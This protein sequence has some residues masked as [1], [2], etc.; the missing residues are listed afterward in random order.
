MPPMA[1]RRPPP[2]RSFSFLTVAS[3]LFASGLLA[4]CEGCRTPGAPG[5]GA[6][7]SAEPP[8]LRLYL[9]SS[10]AGALE[11]CGCSPDQLGGFDRLAAYMRGQGAHAPNALFLEAGPLFFVHPTPHGEQATQDSWKAEAI[12]GALGRMHFAGWAP[13]LNDWCDGPAGFARLRERSK[14]DA[15]AANLR[16]EGA[17]VVP[18]ALREAGGVKVGLLGLSAPQRGGLGPAGVEVGPAPEALRGAIEGLKAQG[19]QIFVALAALPRG[20]A[21]RLA[22]LTPGLHVVLVGKTSEAEDANDKAAPPVLLGDTLVV[23]TANHLQTVGVLDLY[24]RDGGFTFQDAAGVARASERAALVGRV[25][26]LEAKL[27]QW[28]QDPAIARAD[29]KARQDDLER[30]RRE[31]RALETPAPPARGS[32]FRFTNLPVADALGRDEAVYRDM[33]AF[34]QRVNEHNKQAFAGRKPPP[35]EGGQRYVGVEACAGCHQAARDVW[36]GTAHGHAYETLSRQYKEY[37]LECVSCHV[38]GYERPGGSTVTDNAALRG[39]QCESCHGPG[40][41]H[42]ADP[43]KKGLIA[44]Q[45]D[46]QGCVS[47][48]HHPPHVE[49]FDPVARMHKVL[50]PGHGNPES[51]PPKRPRLLFGRAQIDANAPRAVGGYEAGRDEEAHR[52]C[53]RATR[54]PRRVAELAPGLRR[55][56]PGVRA[57]EVSGRAAGERGGAAAEPRPRLGQATGPLGRAAPEPRAGAGEAADV[58]EEAEELIVGEVLAPEHV[59]LAG[60]PAF[61]AEGEPA[62]GVVDV[63]D[64]DAALGARE[65]EEGRAVAQEAHDER[66]EDVVGGE[67]FGGQGDDEGQALLVRV[68]KRDRLGPARRFD[69]RVGVAQ[70]EGVGFVEGRLRAARTEGEGARGERDARDAPPARRLEHL[71]RARFGGRGAP[72]PRRDEGRRRVRE[73]VAA[74]ERAVDRVPDAHVALGELEPLAG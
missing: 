31:L 54:R 13:G 61:E 59:A 30:L 19:A 7:A 10:V 18:T 44:A 1:S 62:G 9:S 2:S 67:G 34:Y 39:V 32:F 22:E 38:T 48:C 26:E 52:A 37:N 65:V 46:P 40:A 17:G 12:A 49:G 68:R 66:A 64:V 16:A 36:A 69:A 8:T 20:E 58:G 51:W 35:P 70:V 47:A 25:E 56:E 21:L 55:R 24:V 43:A 4:A 74:G 57:D 72:A 45:P 73:P 29:F 23:E 3:A 11:P 27:R 60:P 15:L 42:A 50:G 53:D 5:A 28:S 6:S 41:L 63:D 33:L 14:G 71:A